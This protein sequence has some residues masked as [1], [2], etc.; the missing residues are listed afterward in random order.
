MMILLVLLGGAVTG[1]GLFQE[2]SWSV[3]V[4]ALLTIFIVRP[5]IGWISLL[6]TPQAT[7]EKAVI[8]FFGI[9]GLG[10]VYYLAYGLGHA[11]FEVPHLLWSTIGLVIL[12]SVILHGATVTPVMRRLDHGRKRRAI[13]QPHQLGT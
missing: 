5:I 9:R 13:V 11:T 7:D 1:G 2:M 3:V 12:M 8:S 6:G 10:S 4:F